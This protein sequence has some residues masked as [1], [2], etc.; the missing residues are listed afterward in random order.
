[1]DDYKIEQVYILGVNDIFWHW[2]VCGI[3]LSVWRVQYE[4]SGSLLSLIKSIV[5][6][7]L[8]LSPLFTRT[9]GM[10]PNL[11]HYP[12]DIFGRMNLVDNKTTENNISF[13]R[14]NSS[15]ECWMLKCAV[16]LD[17]MS[18]LFPFVRTFY[19]WTRFLQSPALLFCGGLFQQ[20]GHIMTRYSKSPLPCNSALLTLLTVLSALTDIITAAILGISAVKRS[21]GSTTGFHNHGEGP[22]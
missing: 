21:I 17:A 5:T 13:W 6:Q 10:S 7:L 8:T 14:E 1:M 22:Y 19:N 11:S 20:P 2:Y 15:P 4:V 16:I 12:E 9:S 18:V 3:W